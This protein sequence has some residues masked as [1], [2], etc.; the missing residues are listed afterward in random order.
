MKNWRIEPRKLG[1]EVYVTNDEEAIFIGEGYNT[2][3]RKR[4]N[5]LAAIIVE[6]LNKHEK[7]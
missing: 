7:K 4:S 2:K 5:E 6:A 3:E 1:M